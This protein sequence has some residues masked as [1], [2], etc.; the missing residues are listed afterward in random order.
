MLQLLPMILMS[1]MNIG[2]LYKTAVHPN[3]FAR[4]MLNTL[5]DLLQFKYL[6]LMLIFIALYDLH[7]SFWLCY[8]LFASF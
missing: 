8:K 1:R 5:D 2:H 3:L 4:H 7:F 6:T